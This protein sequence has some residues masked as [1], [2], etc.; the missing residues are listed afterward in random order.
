M[1]NRIKEHRQVRA[2]EL[3]P[4]EFNWRRHSEAQRQALRAIL[5]DVGFARS[6]LVYERGDGKLVLIDGHLRAGLDPDALV[7]VEVLD[8]NDAEAR[9]L[10][11]TIDPLAALAGSD[12]DT[13]AALSRITETDQAALQELWQS[14]EA[15]SR[16]TQQLLA[17]AS[18]GPPAGETPAPSQFLILIECKDEA[19]QRELLQRFHEEGLTCKALLS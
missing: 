8:V 17:E 19:E 12:A 3:L 4:H 2:G 18:K 1:K 6:L 11:L 10:L 15:A 9:K 13:V 5:D 7:T 16:Q 14:V